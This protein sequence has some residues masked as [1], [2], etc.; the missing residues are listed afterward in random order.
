MKATLL[1]LISI[2]ISLG[3]SA[4][5]QYLFADRGEKIELNLPFFVQSTLRGVNVK[6]VTKMK[7]APTTGLIYVISLEPK[8]ISLNMQVFEEQYFIEVYARD[9]E[10]EIDFS[11]VNY[12]GNLEFNAG[13]GLGVAHDVTL[14]IKR[15]EANIGNTKYETAMP[16]LVT[17]PIGV[18]VR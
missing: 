6:K 2:F 8:Q 7:S 1:L 5:N 4:S 12:Y 10:N 14:V 15:S 16:F 18:E 17:T 11:A 3:S 9:F 13:P